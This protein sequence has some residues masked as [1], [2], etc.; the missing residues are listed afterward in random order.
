MTTEVTRIDS[1]WR[2]ISIFLLVFSLSLVPLAQGGDARAQDAAAKL[3]AEALEKLVGPIALYPD[4]LVAIV[5]P[6][7]TFPLQVVQAARFLEKRKKNSTLEPVKKWDASVLA[8]LNY[9]DVVKKLNDDLD[10]IWK[11]GEAVVAQQND[12]M[13]A[14]QQFRAKAYTAGNL[15]SDDK[16]VIVQEKEV[17]IIQ[18]ASPEVVYVPSYN[19]AVVVVPSPT[20]AVVYSA[21]YPYYYAPG[22]AFWTGMF[23]GAA[24]GYGIGWHNHDINYHHNY[25]GSGSGGNTVNIGGGDRNIGGG[26][27]NI[28][29]GDPASRQENRGARSEDRQGRRDSGGRARTP[30]SGAKLKEKWSPGRNSGARP[31]G[32]S[33]RRMRTQSSDFKFGYGDRKGAARSPTSRSG[34]S[35]S[36][37][38]S[39]GWG[40]SRSSSS[41]RSSSG[42]GGSSSRNGAFGGYKRGSQ[43][44]RNS[45]RGKQSRSRSQ[46]SRSRS[47]GGGSRSKPSGGS[48]SKPSGGGSRGGGGRRR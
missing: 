21:P 46:S 47:S 23:V 6:A 12:V 17:I 13:D 11:L 4:D 42:R 30:E 31:G 33:G 5:L 43:T 34:S 45:N 18:S 2:G 24:V 27:R 22:A 14:I 28:G 25:S 29:G 32:D 7:S 15:K 20:P 39:S 19:P 44:S 1:F 41:R 10:W 37:R 40:G 36:R 26:D 35:S 3:P 9:P 38:S 16:Q 48:R 8:L